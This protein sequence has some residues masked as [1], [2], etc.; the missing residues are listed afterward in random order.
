MYVIYI[1]Y[2][3][4]SPVF[5]P[6]FFISFISFLPLFVAQPAVLWPHVVSGGRHDVLHDCALA[7]IAL[8][9]GRV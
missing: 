7:R 3:F 4:F 6:P 9:P 1:R 2:I 5:V 8:Q